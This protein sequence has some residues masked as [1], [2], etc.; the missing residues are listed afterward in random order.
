MKSTWVVA[1][2]LVCL[3]M[4]PVAAS[5][6]DRTVVGNVTK[7]DGMNMTVKGQDG[8]DASVLLNAKT[9]VTRGKEKLDVKALK[10][11]DHVVAYG[12]E[13]KST[14]DAK[15]VTITAAPATTN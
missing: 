6:A 1:I 3:V 13:D 2:A 11:G 4:M 14:I 12:P 9:R 10:V 8:K 5:A 7:I 15:T